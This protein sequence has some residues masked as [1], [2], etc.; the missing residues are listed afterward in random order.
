MKRLFFISFLAVTSILFALDP[1]KALIHYNIQI[2]DMDSGLPGNAVFALR[3][4]SDGYLWIGT[5]DGLVRFDGLQLEVY[6][7]DTVPQLKSNDIRALYEDQNGVLWIGTSTGGLVRFKDGQFV[8]YPAAENNALSRIR[9]I[10]EDRW[11]N[12]WIGSFTGGL[13]C[14]NNDQFTTFTTEQGLPASQVRF[15]YQDDNRDLWVTTSAG[16]VK[17]LKPGIFQTYA[18]HDVLPYL[19]T[20]GLY[21]TDAENLWIGT[22]ESGLFQL[23]K[24]IAVAYSTGKE[25]QPCPINTLYKDRKNNLWIGTDGG[26]LRRLKEDAGLACGSVYAITEDREGSLWVGT[27]DR[28][29]FQL[30]D[31]KFVTYTAGDGLSHDIVHC[32]YEGRDNVWIGTEGGLDRVKNGKPTT[33]L[34]T[35]EGLL[36]NSVSCLSEDSA[37]YL[38]IGTWGGLHRFKDGKP[39]T[40]TDKNGLSDNRIKCILQDKQGYTWIG[41]EN[42][43]NRFD[44]RDGKFTVYTTGQGLNGNAIEFIFE[45]HRGQLWIGTNAGLNRLSGGVISAYKL[46]VG[47]EDYFLKCAYEDKEG[48]LWIGTD[49]GL[50]RA[51]GKESAPGAAPTKNTRA[52]LTENGVNTILED[53]RGYLWLAG[54]K[55]ISRVAKKELTDFVFGKTRQVN[56]ETYNEKD[57]M[58]SRWVTGLG[59]KTRDGRLWF[60]TSV[61]VAVI[62]PDHIEKNTRALSPII[63]KFM[64]DGESIKIKS[65]DQTFPKV[66][67]VKHR[68]GPPEAA[69]LELAP[70]K[71]R[72]ELDYTAVSFIDPQKIKFKVKLEG[73]DSDWVDVG[74][75]R[76][77]AYNNL[78]PGHYTF[79]VTACN[80]DGSWSEEGASL[81]FHL[82]PYFYQTSWFYIFLFIMV[83]LLVYG[84]YRLRVKQIKDKAKEL[85]ELVKQRTHALEKQ[86]LQLEEAHQKLQHTNDLVE[87]KNRQLE[88]QSEQLKEL[89]KAKSRF[90]ANITHEFRTP[91]TLIIGPLE[92]ILSENPDSKMKSTAGLMMRNSKR[93][94]NLV[95]QLLEL[96]KFDSG[97]LKLQFSKQNIVPFLKSIFYCFQSLAQQNNIEFACICEASEIHVYYDRENLERVITNLLGNS[98]NYTPKGGRITVSLKQV[99]AAGVFPCGSVEIYVQ[100]NGP[101]IPADQLPH[102]FDRFYRGTG[103]GYMHKGA[104]IGLALSK[105]LVEL[106]HGRIKVQSSC[107]EDDARGVSFIVCLPLGADHLAAGEVVE[108]TGKHP[109]PSSQSMDLEVFETAAEAGSSPE[110]PG[111]PA[112]APGEVKNIVLV[113]E[114]NA[115]VR[116]YIKEALE[117]NFKIEEAADGREGIAKARELIPDLIISDIIMPAVDGFELCKTLKTG[118][119]TSHIPIIILTA[120]IGEADVLKGF[121]YGADDYITKPFNTRVLAA[122]ARNLIDLRGQ[123]QLKR[124]NQM[125]LQP[126]EITVLPIDEAFYRELTGIIEKHITD[127]EFSVPRLAE[128]M[129]MGRTTL[130]KKIQAVTGESPNQFIRNYRL[131]RAAQLLT[132]APHDA[133]IAEIAAG[134]GFN[135]FSHFSKCFKERFGQ[136]P[137]L[138]RDAHMENVTS[139]EEEATWSERPGEDETGQLEPDREKDVVLIVEDNDDARRYIR[140][141]L[142]PGCRVEEA[143]GGKQG[144]EIAF[145]VMPDLIVSDIMM[146][147]VDGYELCRTLK[148]DRRTSHIPIVLLTAKVSD[149]SVVLGLE[150]GAD[151]Y[152][153][154]P[155]NR[156]ILRVRIRNLVN[157]RRQMQLRRKR[158]MTLAPDLMQTSGMDEEFYREM[159]KVIEKHLDEADFSIDDLSKELYMGRTTLYRKVLALSGET[160]EAFIRS[161]RLKR[162]AQLLRKKSGSI[163]DVALE[164][165]FSSS[166]YFT[167]C[168]KEKFHQ[169]PSEI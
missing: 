102:I 32:I 123:L 60:P 161:Y 148:N 40:F 159:Q 42:G 131:Q 70:G 110:P 73:F 96:A 133:G 104:G 122:R 162:A 153:T 61:G 43:L 86:K 64:V 30:R 94:L 20:A 46:P 160:P 83:S 23:K 128:E 18:A 75:Q 59:C 143:A 3:Q 37:G 95:N 39:T 71:R 19:K 99:P 27:L 98:F 21:E 81:S 49:R 112:G 12:L 100:N 149:E 97:K 134:V 79:A 169:L 165:G 105:E 93:L 117:P 52:R 118:I 16:I 14:L 127:V 28:G 120:K 140:E 158:Q 22:G 121:S 88:D 109:Y 167:H 115:D 107:Q 36:N 114:D 106:H 155:F 145:E 34:T 152:I 8:S 41:T 136:L 53:D 65:F 55:G 47:E 6:T 141:T 124:Q 125:A 154:K 48:T 80:Q 33:V 69:S 38:W 7:R 66:W 1:G 82:R 108:V 77:M 11:G 92:L 29:L 68:Q 166:S 87:T 85:G 10:A 13:A 2:W 63:E 44:N 58:K 111:A 4:T 150:T 116:R 26:G 101:G 129:A 51:Q 132:A 126:D 89:D 91:L 138:Y 54:R 168:F 17:V 113:V 25:V 74:A 76:S 57:G 135:D 45:D 9:A 84:G 156:E 78:S 103:E 164:V 67:S 163:L 144:I 90:F 147:N 31:S 119:A 5:Q 151:D 137:T 15:I 62:D 50:I 139:A 72:L 35:G 146:A 24:G 142:E 157:L 130:F 56:S